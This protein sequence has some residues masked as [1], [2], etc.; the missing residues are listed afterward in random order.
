MIRSKPVSEKFCKGALRFS[1]SKV[2][3]AGHGWTGALGTGAETMTSSQTSS[4]SPSDRDNS[5]H[6]LPSPPFDNVVNAAAG[7]G[8]TVIVKQEE[9]V[10]KIYVAGRPYDFQTL[11]RFYRMP[12]VVR[13]FSTRQSLLFERNGDPGLFGKVADYFLANTKEED[14]EEKYR[15]SIFP[16]FTEIQLPEGDVPMRGDCYHQKTLSA[17]AGL[18]AILGKSEGRVY[19]F[20]INQRGQCGTGDRTAHHIWEPTPVILKTGETLEGVIGDPLT[21]ITNVDLGLQ[22]GIA[23]DRD[24]KLYGWGKG[25]RGQLG[26]SKFKSEDV[27]DGIESSVDIEFG[28]IQIND[29]IIGTATS[30]NQLTGNCARVRNISAGWNHSAAITESNHVFCWGK[31]AMAKLAKDGILKAVDAPAPTPVQGLPLDMEVRDVACGSHHSSILME[32]GSVYA[33]GI[34]TDTAEPIGERAVQIIPPGL[35]DT[36]IKQFSSHFDRTTIIAGDNNEQVIEV[37]LWSTDELRN[38]ALFEPEWVETLTADDSTI[39]MVH[40]GWLHTL[41]TTN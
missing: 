25:S 3:I 39:Q 29:F 4:V 36:P 16:E 1:S 17:S 34:T 28:A 8:H 23:L 41:V 5:F 35:I 27:S 30:T 11:L 38:S 9:D 12:E 19:T 22:H 2:H 21:D 18:T 10:D 40:R 13:R 24:G 15:C 31:N 32:D 37:Q 20:G 33:I 26:R 6:A 7:W 14:A